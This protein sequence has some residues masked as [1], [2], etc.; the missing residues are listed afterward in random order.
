MEQD[1]I[2]FWRNN[3]I[4][5]KSVQKNPENN[6]YVFYDGPPFISGLPHYGHLIVSIVKD[7]IPRYWTM[8]GKRV[9]RL[10]GWD[11]HGLTVENK[12]QK[13]LGI[14]NRKE[15]ENY[16]LEKFTQ[17]CYD[18]TSQVSGEWAWYI[19]RVGRWVD[20]EHAY[21]TTDQT[22]MES[23]IWA[24]SELY[25]KGLIYEG[26]RTSLYCTTCGTPVS[27]FEIAM[28]NSYREVED[29][30]IIVEFKVTTPG[31]FKDAYIL[32]WTTTPWTI[33]S[34][35]ALV[36]D[37]A[38]TYVRVSGS[39]PS[40]IYI[41][42]KKR[43][44]FVFQDGN[45]KILEEFQ[46]SE[47]VGLCYEPPFRIYS[48]VEPGTYQV[49][50]F[51]GMVTMEEGTG[52]VHSA[53]GFGEI[54]TEMGQKYGLR[55]MLTLDDE[56][57]FLEGDEN[58]NPYKGLTY[59]EANEKINHDLEIKDMLFRSERASHRVPYHDRCDT[60]LI[61]KAQ[62][63]WFVA[64]QGMKADLLANNE[65]INWIPPHLKEGRFKQNIEGAPDWCIS[66]SRFWA[67]PMPVWESAD[68]ERVVVSSVKELEELSGKKIVDLHRPYID[69]VTFERDNKLFTRRKEVLDC[70]FESGSMPYGQFHYPFENKEKFDAN[71]PGDFIV[72][73]IPQTRAWFYVTH[74]L[75]TALFG[76]KAFKNALGYGTLAGN[77]GRK[78]SKT[79][80]NYTDPREVLENYGGDAL[81]LFYMGS[82]IMLGDN[83]NFDEIE[84]KNKLKRVL[85]PLWNCV[86]FFSLYAGSNKW[87]VGK[88]VESKHILDLWIKVRLD[89][90]IWE[91]SDNLEKYLIP[92]AVRALEDFVDDL[93]RWYVRRSRERISSGDT[94]ALSTLYF[95]LLRF[96]EACAPIIPFISESMYLELK[97][98]DVT[99][100]EES[101]HL[102][103]YPTGNSP[104]HE[105]VSLIEH[106]A[107]AKTIS[108]IILSI[109]TEKGLAVRQPLS[110]AVV[111]STAGEMA[112]GLIALIKD[113]VNVKELSFAQTL[114]QG[115]MWLVKEEKGVSIAVNIEL[116]EDL[117][118]EGTARELMRQIQDLR[119]EK[120]LTVDQKINVS[121]KNTPQNVQAVER[122]QEEIKAK[123]G[124]VSLT[125]ADEFLVE[126]V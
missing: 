106:M 94:G 92:P 113:E 78:M 108:S 63:S 52:I 59:I 6:S 53:P 17:A 23:V 18:Y 28:D 119:K 62:K 72:E 58:P 100:A 30:S 102:R 15:I 57:K 48:A 27:N 87:E 86:N 34:H 55:L 43:L 67:T 32:A 122:F 76:K 4:F 29:Y 93:S 56:G 50:A 49:Y 79:Y 39:V 66:R 126:S 14:K 88:L 61:Q 33:P 3:K 124:A 42:A 12:V 104:S 85:N 115:E 120:C 95:V 13:K 45:Y 2:E 20:F 82:P 74:V 71:Y 19:D 111:I 103:N 51:E 90:V 70:W 68:G 31:K 77:D 21:K 98:F 80:A 22:Y 25:K 101:V 83:I 7:V 97:K 47:L 36:V 116:T 91:V 114:P 123:V 24:F 8:Q 37:P 9:E 46:G 35:R 40:N 105:E 65:H 54:D 69:D 99:L 110:E 75:S 11:A 117:K 81:R 16:G 26:V 89:Q 60:N 64:I 107:L 41:L 10:W 109:R 5:E 1:I 118:V 84:I 73:Y 96:A 38:E 112:E 44:E 125:P 121:Y